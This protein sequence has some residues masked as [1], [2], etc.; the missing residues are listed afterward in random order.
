MVRGKDIIAELQPKPRTA[1]F[2]TKCFDLAEHF[3][4]DEPRKF[5]DAEHRDLA[6]T[7]QIAIEDWLAAAAREGG[8]P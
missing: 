8:R 4:A 3:L 6:G 7:I 2:D 1:T 5:T